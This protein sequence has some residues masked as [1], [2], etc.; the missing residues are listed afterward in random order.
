[1]IPQLNINITTFIYTGQSGLSNMQNQDESFLRIWE[2]PQL[3][4]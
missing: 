4:W 1:M 3:L 2:A